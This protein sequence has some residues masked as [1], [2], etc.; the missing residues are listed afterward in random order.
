MGVQCSVCNHTEQESIDRALVAGTSLRTI[1][2]EYGVSI[3]SLSRHR[4]AGHV[5]PAIVA[6]QAAADQVDRA[7]A[8]TM[9][10]RLEDQY[11]I[12]AAVVADARESG[13]P[14][15]IINASREMRQTAE[16]L[17]KITGEL[18]EQQVTV[19]LLTH[20]EVLA[21][22]NVVNAELADLPDLRERI[23]ERLQ[24]EAGPTP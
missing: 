15:T 17:A 6:M 13:S 9:L 8:T 3:S 23:A 7:K 12:L 16:V 1:R 19:N 14:T 10:E 2:G 22:I 11:G 18:R 24:L 5:S 4:K 20:P 21:A